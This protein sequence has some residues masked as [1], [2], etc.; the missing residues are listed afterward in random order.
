MSKVIFTD[1]QDVEIHYAREMSVGYK[2]KFY[3]Y[4]KNFDGIEAIKEALS[5][6]VFFPLEDTLDPKYGFMFSGN[7]P[8][9]FFVLKH[10]RLTN[11]MNRNV[12]MHQTVLKGSKL[13]VDDHPF[14]GKKDVYWCYFLWSFFDKSVLGYPHSYAFRGAKIV[15]GIDP[16]DCRMLAGKV[17]PVTSTTIRRIYQDDIKVTRISM[18]A[19]T[20]EAY[21][22]EK[23]RLFDIET[24]PWIIIRKLKTFINTMIPEL[25]DGLSL[26]NVG[27]VH[28][29]YKKGDRDLI[30]SDA[31]V[32]TFLESEFWNHIRNV[33]TFM[34]ALW[35]GC[36]IE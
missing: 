29:Q 2:S 10:P 8:S 16:F 4:G 18:D 19:A 20:K 9:D 34:G 5:D 12:E 1:R 13:V 26:I 21:E 22:H 7:T 32:D 15:G 27:H 33:N 14:L 24:R 30:V 3:V 36:A 11:I 23:E 28:E 31:G 25:R 35:D 6:F 17:L